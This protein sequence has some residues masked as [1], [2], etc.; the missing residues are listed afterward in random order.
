MSTSLHETANSRLRGVQQ[1]YTRGRQTLVDILAEAGRPLS[2]PEILAVDTSV[3]QSS[4]YRNLTTLELAGV[5]RKVQGADEFSR[6]EL[7]EDLTEHHHHLVCTSCGT[8][9]DY[10]APTHVEH[11]MAQAI[12]EI[13]GATGFRADFHR[14]DLIGVCSR[15]S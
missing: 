6:F 11:T 7:A 3:P 2:I 13:A 5:V 9:D 8:V 12:D 1:R 15:C 14:V 4:V 10:T